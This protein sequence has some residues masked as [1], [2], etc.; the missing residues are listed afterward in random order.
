MF[1]Q[2]T[3]INRNVLNDGSL[4]I[5]HCSSISRATRSSSRRI[6]RRPALARR[7]ATSSA[8][9]PAFF[10]PRRRSVGQRRC[11]AFVSRRSSGPTTSRSAART[12]PIPTIQC[13]N[14]MSRHWSRRLVPRRITHSPVRHQQCRAGNS[15]LYRSPASSA[16]S[17]ALMGVRRSLSADYPIDIHYEHGTNYTGIS[18]SAT[19]RCRVGSTASDQRDHVERRDR[20]RA[21]PRRA[22]MADVHA[23]FSRGSAPVAL[24]LKKLPHGRRNLPARQQRVACG[25]HAWS[26]AQSTVCWRRQA[27]SGA[28]TATRA[29]GEVVPARISRA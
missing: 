8:V 14:L 12:A 24:D 15:R 29:G 6:E 26:S 25:A 11:R 7:Q 13:A 3:L 23:E 10:L 21:T 20:L 17:Q 1:R 27:A 4:N 2:P 16:S 18:T 19:S 9:C 5:R 22:L 28:L